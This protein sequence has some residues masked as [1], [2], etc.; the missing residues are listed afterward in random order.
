MQLLIKMY[1]VALSMFNYQAYRT[2]SLAYLISHSSIVAV[3]RYYVVIM[4]LSC[5][6]CALIVEIG[7]S[8]MYSSLHCHVHV[9]IDIAIV[10]STE[11][12]QK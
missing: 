3:I 10:F 12:H 1:L 4:S 6:Y 9:R 5:N 7:Q 8:Y 11:V 2:Y